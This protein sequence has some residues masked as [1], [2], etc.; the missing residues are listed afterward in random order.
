MLCSAKR[1]WAWCI[2]WL[3]LV[4]PSVTELNDTVQEVVIVF[5]HLPK[6]ILSAK[7]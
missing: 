6:D 5:F 4:L 3:N 1:T 2:G 7:E